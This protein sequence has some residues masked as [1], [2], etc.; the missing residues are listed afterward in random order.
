[1]DFTFLYRYRQVMKAAQLAIVFL[2]LWNPN[3]ATAQESLDAP[4]ISMSL[5]RGINFL[6]Q[7]SSFQ[8]MLRFRMQ[9]LV[10]STKA[11]NKATPWTSLFQIR[12]MRIK[13][14]GWAFSPK[15][16]YK[17]ELGLGSRD[18]ANLSEEEE[19][20]GAARIILDAVVK[21]NFAKNLSLWFG[22]TKVPGN[23]QRLIS[24][25]QLQMVDRSTLNDLFNLDRDIGLQIHGQLPVGKAMLKPRGSIVMGEGRDLV[26]T[27]K[28]GFAYTGR[29]DF[30]PFGNFIGKGD[31]FE[32]DLARE[33]SPKLSVGVSV[34]F[35]QGAVRQAGQRGRFLKDS[36]G[37]YLSAD[38][39]TVFLDLM[40]K[41]QGWSVLAEYADKKSSEFVMDDFGR[42]FTTGSGL[43]VQI[44][45]LFKCNYEVVGKYTS[46]A[47]DHD[48][49]F[50]E[51][52]EYAIGLS[53]Y[54]R[55][56]TLKIQTDFAL[57]DFA[58][59]NDLNFR[60]RFQVELGI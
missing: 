59:S 23:R 52:Q 49:T 8:M 3:L 5:G 24:S 19:V 31:Y 51:H 28:G 20:G 27:N 38:L 47:P 17:L 57:L 35:N 4:H 53:K 1:M 15:I 43:N 14:D 56:H 29:I 26:I 40:F 44:G 33:Q 32:T 18:V 7:D 37:N 42:S 55:N 12:R 50:S 48:F 6:A 46:V 58:D 34:D 2:L 11:L 9:N 16:V 30:M 36:S 21:W 13:L 10:V 22:Q 41:Y 39:T 60:W 25:Q 45:Y 54:I